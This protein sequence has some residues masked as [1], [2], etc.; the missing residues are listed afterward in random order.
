MTEKKL[1]RA[2]SPESLGIDSRLI[3]AFLDDI[4]EQGLELH[5][6]MLTRHGKVAAECYWTPFRADIPH[7]MFSVSKSITALAVGFAIEEGLLTEDTKVYA[8]F[9]EYAPKHPTPAAKALTV[10]HL[11]T[12]TSGKMPSFILNTE[13]P[14][15]VESYLGAP[16]A[17]M[18]GKHFNYASENTYM[19]AAVVKKVTGECVLDY[20]Q[21][22]LFAPLGIERPFWETDKGGTEVG[23]WGLYLKTEDVA[24]IINC[25][26]NS[27][28]FDGVQVIPKF[29]AKTVGRAHVAQTPG[30]AHDHNSGY[31]YCFWRNSFPESYRCDGVFSQLA[32]AIPDFDTCIITTGG[33]PHERKVLETFWKYFPTKFK[34]NPLDENP[35]ALAEMNSKLASRSLPKM[36]TGARRFDVEE[37]VNGKY[38]KFRKSRSLSSLTVVNNF[39]RSKKSGRLNNICFDFGKDSLRMRWTEKYNEMDVRIG[40]NG[41]Y[42]LSRV[43]LADTEFTFASTSGWLSD[44]SFEVWLRPLEHAQVKKFNFRFLPNNKVKC[45]NWSEQDLY[46]LAL[47]ALDFK[48]IKADDAL[49][50]IA[51][52]AADIVEPVV[53]PDLIGKIVE[54]PKF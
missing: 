4:E 51:K 54:P 42:I 49:K 45:K 47:F 32:V 48:G 46:Q 9:P 1:I 53:D 29:W 14:S 23:G 19:L 18:P 50:A 40:Y 41:E 35:A 6:F 3:T 11:L 5:S 52:G 10:R 8:V 43:K 33:E 7:T 2:E 26:M 28:V 22:R 34:D 30:V 39:T 16:F 31:G 21:P 24:K 36:K 25:V 27:G 17:R 38:I 15:W 37:K 13:G 20:L 12:M 44:G